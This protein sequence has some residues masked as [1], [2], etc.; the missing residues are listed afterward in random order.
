MGAGPIAKGGSRGV[1]ADFEIAEQD[2]LELFDGERA[3]RRAAAILGVGF[4]ASEQL[5]L[6]PDE[7]TL[8]LRKVASIRPTRQRTAMGLGNLAQLRA[9]AFSI[10]AGPAGCVDRHN[11]VPGCH[12]HWK[13]KERSWTTTILEFDHYVG[14]EIRFWALHSKG[15][16]TDQVDP[17]MVNLSGSKR[18]LLHKAM[19]D[20]LGRTSL[21]ACAHPPRNAVVLYPAAGPDPRACNRNAPAPSP[22]NNRPARQERQR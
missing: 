9:L 2:I 3:Q 16:R 20:S 18:K 17:A 1:V 19:V 5:A 11:H 4:E 21:D 12:W 13:R 7:S 22:R 15:G 10:Q 8:A 6:G 14:P